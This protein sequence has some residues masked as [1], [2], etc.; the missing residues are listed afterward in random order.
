MR[1]PGS[2]VV[3]GCAVDAYG[4]KRLQLHP[5]FCT[6]SDLTGRT[7][8]LQLL[9][10]P[11]A[12]TIMDRL[13]EQGGSAPLDCV[14]RRSD[15]ERGTKYFGRWWQPFSVFADDGISDP[16]W[17]FRNPQRLLGPGRA[18]RV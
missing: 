9:P 17:G 6:S 1:R 13:T 16:P 7:A 15:S 4:K 5:R 8:R 12:I 14:T 11:M 3:C 18:R 2:G 10:L